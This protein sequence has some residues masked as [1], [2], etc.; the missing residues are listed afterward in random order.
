MHSKS[1]LLTLGCG[2][3][4]VNIYFRAP[5]KENGR[6]LLT[7]P[8]LP[9]GF[10]GKVFKDRVR[11]R[12]VGYMI[13]SHPILGSVGDEVIR[14]QQYQPSGSTQSGLCVFVVSMHLTF[15][16]WW[17]FRYLQNSS[18]YYLRI[19]GSEYYL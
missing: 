17:R 4:K 18:E 9:N 16:T 6:R 2:E 1:N 13:S 19:F 10:Q 5:R 3:G 7:R 11:E 8:K 14:N 12:V 15:S